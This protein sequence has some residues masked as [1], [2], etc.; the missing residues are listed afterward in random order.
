MKT[1]T[2]LIEAAEDV[3]RSEDSRLENERRNAEQKRKDEWNGRV[4]RL[5]DGLIT[6]KK[7]HENQM[8]AASKPDSSWVF[9]GIVAGYILGF[10]L[11]LILGGKGSSVIWPIYIP[12]LIL[13]VIALLLCALVG[14][15]LGVNNSCSP[16]SSDTGEV[17]ATIGGLVLV[18]VCV[19]VCC[20]VIGP[21]LSKRREEQ[22]HTERLGQIRA[23]G[24]W[25]KL[26]GT[27][28]DQMQEELERAKMQ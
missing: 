9:P 16:G 8:T 24:A 15:V 11:F 4:K 18:G 1:V 26:S 5:L 14:S 7:H 12:L 22:R 13:L 19:I 20:C 21:L 17:T 6:E 3:F 28:T 25:L 10:V 23:D 2:E 27:T